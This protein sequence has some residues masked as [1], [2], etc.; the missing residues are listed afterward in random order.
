MICGHMLATGLSY[1]SRC[2]PA[3]I[4]SSCPPTTQDHTSQGLQDRQMSRSLNFPVDEFNSNSQCWEPN[5]PFLQ[6]VPHHADYATSSLSSALDVNLSCPVYS[7]HS[8]SHREVLHSST[9]FPVLP[10]YGERPYQSDEM[11]H[12]DLA[13]P[14]LQSPGN[15]LI[16]SEVNSRIKEHRCRTC[17]KTFDRNSTL[18]KVRFKSASKQQ[19]LIS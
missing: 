11:T 12:R 7:N 4:C 16:K 10:F 17:R 3:G 1:H 5:A 14:S 2:F 15:T 18:L 8:E 13:A 9:S 19:D 6:W